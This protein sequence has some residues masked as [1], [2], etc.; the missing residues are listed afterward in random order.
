MELEINNCC[1]TT[2][3]KRLALEQVKRLIDPIQ[4]AL[5]SDSYS[6]KDSGLNCLTEPKVLTNSQGL[7]IGLFL[8]LK[9]KE[10]Y[11]GKTS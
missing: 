11:C 4:V 9:G 2:C 7:V 6:M 3:N 8:P 1:G 5:T 10:L